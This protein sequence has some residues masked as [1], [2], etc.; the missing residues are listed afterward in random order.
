MQVR[1]TILEHEVHLGWEHSSRWSAIFRMTTNRWPV[2]SMNWRNRYS[3]S[4]KVPWLASP[5]SL[6]KR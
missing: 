5:S 4:A 1:F 3:R 2:Y 6:R